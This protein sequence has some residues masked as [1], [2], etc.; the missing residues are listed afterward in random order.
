MKTYF[1]T[2]HKTEIDGFQV[3]ASVAP[4]TDFSPEDLFDDSI[5][6]IDEIHRKINNGIYQWF[7]IRVQVMKSGKELGCSSIGGLLYEDPMEVMTDGIYADCLD[8]AMREA[9][10]FVKIIKEEITI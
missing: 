7:F 10:K 4:E 1:E 3:I 8:E 6:D 2:I 9:V 5:D